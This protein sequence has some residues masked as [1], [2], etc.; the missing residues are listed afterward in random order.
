MEFIEKFKDNH[1]DFTQK[2]K[3]SVF[4]EDTI[5][6]S[7][8][9]EIHDNEVQNNKRGFNDISEIFISNYDL[10]Y[11]LLENNEKNSYC[12]KKKLEIA[13][14]LGDKNFNY[15]SKFTES[16]I[17]N[18]LQDKNKFSSILYLNDYFNCNLIIYNVSTKKYYKTGIK[19]REKI[20]CIFE[21]NQW[22]P[23]ENI[24]D[25]SLTEKT[26]I[27][28]ITDLDKIIKFDIQTNLI[29]QYYLKNISKYKMNDLIDICKDLNINIMNGTKKKLKKKLYDEINLKKLNE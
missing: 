18:G 6:D 22:F 7:N 13:S 5:K 12:I 14:D 11:K 10:N 27:N 29:Y 9:E 26:Y 28:D 23:Y 3:N 25:E 1:F 24:N 4:L 15:N 19:D 2:I 16:L 8:K 20:G 21:N 17:C